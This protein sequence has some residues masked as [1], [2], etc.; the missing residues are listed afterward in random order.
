MQASNCTTT[1]GA[2][3]CLRNFLAALGH[4]LAQV[5][6]Q[7]RAQPVVGGQGRLCAATEV[8]TRAV[9]GIDI[10][11]AVSLPAGSVREAGGWSAAER[12]QSVLSAGIVLPWSVQADIGCAAAR[13]V[14]ANLSAQDRSRSRSNRT[15]TGQDRHSHSHKNCS[16]GLPE[17]PVPSHPDC[18]LPSADQHLLE[19]GGQAGRRAGRQAGPE[20][21]QGRRGY[22]SAEMEWIQAGRARHGMPV[23]GSAAGTPARP[24]PPT[25][26]SNT[27]AHPAAHPPCIQ[28]MRGR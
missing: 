22:T 24:H 9:L 27:A 17:L 14:Q 1:R 7:A 20:R 23:T 12:G 15:T 25:H 19:A 26:T 18:L 13:A 3:L 8:G 28:L 5:L 16:I 2:C 10:G 11:E 21:R 4:L 6:N